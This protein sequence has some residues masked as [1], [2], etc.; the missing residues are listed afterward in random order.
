M[1]ALKPVKA[2]RQGK[3]RASRKKAGGQQSTRSVG[4]GGAGVRKTGSGVREPR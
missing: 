2:A 1:K 3:P 4:G